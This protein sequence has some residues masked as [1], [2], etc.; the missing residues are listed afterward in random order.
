MLKFLQLLF[1]DGQF[2]T[3]AHFLVGTLHSI[4]MPTCPEIHSGCFVTF[5]MTKLTFTQQKKLGLMDE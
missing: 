4:Y 2:Y 3:N 1:F 5:K